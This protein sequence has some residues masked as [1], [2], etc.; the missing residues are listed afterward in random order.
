MRPKIPGQS[1][2]ILAKHLNLE[3]KKSG[4]LSPMFV[5]DADID[6]IESKLPKDKSASC[7]TPLAVYHS[8]LTSLVG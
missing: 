8:V 2:Y 4:V 1:G 5:H 7:G 6:N 3:D